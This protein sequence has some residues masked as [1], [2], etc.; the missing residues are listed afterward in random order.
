MPIDR[1]FTAFTEEAR[2]KIVAA[3][4][5]GNFLKT[6]CNFARVSD[7][8]VYAYMQRA[9]ALIKAQEMGLPITLSEKDEVIL[10]F[11]YDVKAAEAEAENVC[12]NTFFGAGSENWQA[13]RGF[14]ERRFRDNWG[15]GAVLDEE[16]AGERPK[17]VE[18]VEPEDAD[19]TSDSE[20][21]PSIVLG[22]KDD[23]EAAL[24]GMITKAL[25]DRP[26]S[27]A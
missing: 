16:P 8:S 24:E 13:A 19:N 6:A 12:V 23:A 15:P 22:D 21:G 20:L 11:Y 10:Q 26:D 17:V 27:D 7:S 18:V 2:E 5:M 25:E 14:L 1:P 9:R 4:R 3:V